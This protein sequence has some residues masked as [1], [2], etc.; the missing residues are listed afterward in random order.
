MAFVNQ[1]TEVEMDDGTLV[2]IELDDRDLLY[3]ADM[4]LLMSGDSTMSSAREG[5]EGHELNV[6]HSYTCKYFDGHNCTAYEERP[7]MCRDYPYGKQCT[8]EG[9]T[10]KS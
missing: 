4:L 6:N 7:A 9:C 1:E 3:I 10:L 5:E 2:T 8:F